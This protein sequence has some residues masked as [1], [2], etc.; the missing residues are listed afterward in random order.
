[1][2]GF[3]LAILTLLCGL[4]LGGCD[5]TQQKP[6]AEAQLGAGGSGDEAD[7]AGQ[8]AFPVLEKS[9]FGA[10]CLGCHSA[11]QRMGGVVLDSLSDVLGSQ[12]VDGG[13]SIVVPGQ[14][15]ASVL[16]QQVES[17]AMPPS[18]PHPDAATVQLLKGWI[19]A[20]AAAATA[21]PAGGQP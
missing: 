5:F 19:D 15:A 14:S 10:Y 11:S 13:Q 3:G 17:G 4:S 12:T 1:M 20:G 16:Y 7:T 6:G 2:R 18:G 9:L 8:P 21:V